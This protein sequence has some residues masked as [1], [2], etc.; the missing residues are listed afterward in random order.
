VVKPQRE[1]S[2][3]EL[4]LMFCTSV[5]S[6]RVSAIVRSQGLCPSSFSDSNHEKTKAI[7]TPNLNGFVS[8]SLHVLG[9]TFAYIILAESGA[10][11]SFLRCL[12]RL[13]L[14]MEFVK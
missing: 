6:S 12:K 14:M 10:F 4:K 5:A 1:S 8:L 13:G 9:V 3:S 11:S 2:S 7:Q